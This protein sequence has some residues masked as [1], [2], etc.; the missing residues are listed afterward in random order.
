MNQLMQLIKD[1][2]GANMAEYATVL[3]LIVVAVVTVVTTLGT[4]IAT[5]ISKATTSLPS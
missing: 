5:V 2:D 1:E 3:G 4:R